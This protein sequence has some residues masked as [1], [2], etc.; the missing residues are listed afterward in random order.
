MKENYGE[1]MPFQ[2]S[3]IDNQVRIQLPTQIQEILGLQPDTDIVI[4]LKEDGILIKPK[5]IDAPITQKFSKMNLP[6]SDWKDM[7][8]E[9]ESGY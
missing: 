1:S 7:E 8:N 6:V 3:K 2:L 9:I 4:E 5:K